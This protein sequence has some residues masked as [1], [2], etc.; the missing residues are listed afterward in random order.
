VIA[1]KN[2]GQSVFK[3]IQT[4][5]SLALADWFTPYNWSYLRS[6]DLDLNDSVLILPNQPGT[7]PH[8]AIAVGKEGTLYV[9]DRDHMGGL[10]STCSTGDTQIVQE[11]SKAVGWNTGSLVYWNDRLYSSGTGSPIMAWSLNYGL[12]ST[13]PI[14]KTIRVAGEHSPVLSSS[15]ESNGILW[16]INGSNLTAYNAMTLQRIYA[17]SQSG[18]RDALPA[19]P[20]FAQLVEVNGKV[21]VGTNSSLVVFGLL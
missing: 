9:L 8:L 21:Y 14:A 18:A 3:L 16:Q 11:L 10:C 1:G 6:N 13:T 12:L 5:S 17:G 19:L 15:A 7:Y 20:H 2:F 4:T